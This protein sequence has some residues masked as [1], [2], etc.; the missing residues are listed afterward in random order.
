MNALRAKEYARVPDL[1]LRAAQEGD[2]RGLVV[3]GRMTLTGDGV[4]KDPA[5]GV[6]YLREAVAKGSRAGKFFLGLSLIQGAAGP[7][8]PVQGRSLIREAADLGHPLAQEWLGQDLLEG[9]PSESQFQEA[10]TWLEKASAQDEA[11]ATASLANLLFYGKGGPKDLPRAEALARKALGR[12]VAWAQNVLFSVLSVTN[13]LEE[14]TLPA[15]PFARIERS[16]SSMDEG[17][18]AILQALGDKWIAPWKALESHAASRP[19]FDLVIIPMVRKTARPAEGGENVKPVSSWEVPK[20][21]KLPLIPVDSVKQEYEFLSEHGVPSGLRLMPGSQSL[22]MDP[23]R[24]QLEFVDAT[25]QH[26]AAQ[27]AIGS[28]FGKMGKENAPLM[29]PEADALY[30]D[31]RQGRIQEACEP[32]RIKRLASASPSLALVPSVQ[33]LALMREQKPNAAKLAESARQLRKQLPFNR[34]AQ[35]LAG[36]AFLAAG[37]AKEA[38]LQK[39]WCERLAE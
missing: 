37:D 16:A 32:K 9:D 26:W 11:S 24:D 23:A 13:R 14:L 29:T 10:R 25:G 6:G 8:D 4:P 22:L 18:G 3:L 27:F 1:L 12:G 38:A 19:P 15:D 31:L 5:K 21:A 20:G 33:I 34:W 7:P 17:M 30:A 28:F 39:G 35:L 2:L 36:L